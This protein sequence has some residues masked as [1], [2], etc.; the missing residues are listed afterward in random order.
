M[1]VGLMLKLLN[2]LNKSILCEPLARIILFYL[3]SLINSVMNLHEFNILFITHPKKELLIVK[4]DH[5]SPTRL[6]YKANV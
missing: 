6:F 4:N 3:T 2:E 1:S 5:F